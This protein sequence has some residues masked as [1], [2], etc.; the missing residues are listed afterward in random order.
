MKRLY[1]I[2]LL[3]LVLLGVSC[4]A[5]EHPFLSKVPEIHDLMTGSVLSPRKVAEA[6]GIYGEW[7]T[8]LFGS[9][10]SVTFIRISPE[11]YSFDILCAEGERADSTSALCSRFGALAGING[12]YFNMRE[13]TPVTYVKDDGFTVG[14][15]SMKEASRT[16]GVFLSRTEGVCIEA[17]D[18]TGLEDGAWEAMAS[19]PILIDDGEVYT[20]S[21]STPGWKGFFNAR[22]PRSL[23]GTDA[24]GYVW[25]VVVDGRS[26]GHAGGMTIAE[27]TE[28]SQMIGL[29]DALNL[30]GGGSS[31]LWTRSAGVLNH[32]SDNGRFDHFGQRVVPNIIAIR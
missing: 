20:Y 4:A 3:T 13:L 29:T 26:E 30:D 31:T 19:G 11:A 32:P 5:P 8:E 2:V 25:L 10:Q 17:S 28:L 15:T 12:S 9:P 23:V 14:T 18:T 27:L 21:E 24:E 22:H 7:Q 1:H 6:P 16:N